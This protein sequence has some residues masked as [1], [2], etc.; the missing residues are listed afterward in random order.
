VG[1]GGIGS[2]V[3][4]FLARLGVG[5]FVL[6][7]PDALE[8][9]NLSRVVGATIADAAHQTLKVDVARR[10]ISDANPNAT[11]E[12]IAD[13]VA[14]QSVAATLRSVDYVFLAA[15]SMRARLVF[16]ALVHQYLIPGVQLGSKIRVDERGHVV[17]VMSAIRPVRP[18]MGCLWCNHLVDPAMLAIEAKTDRERIEQAYGVAEPNPSVIA[19]NAVSAAHAVN[20]F[21]L[22][23]LG[24]R[25]PDP[26]VQF[27]HFH[28]L[29]RAK[30]DRVQPRRDEQCSECSP[31]GR[32]YGRGDTIPL[33]V[34]EG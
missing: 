10:V 7:D 6:I 5:S 2:L 12:S 25:E 27:E 17:D 14:K 19:L 31:A 8:P 33:P 4:E 34:T 21:M 32:R 1:L 9:S 23:Y 28:F 24:L 22:D 20:A 29:P 26:T 30:V 16:N 11:V 18:G 15:D 3:A 13:D